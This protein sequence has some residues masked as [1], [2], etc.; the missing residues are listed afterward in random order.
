M[1]NPSA[2][3]LSIRFVRG[4]GDAPGT[5]A[6]ALALIERLR[7]T[8]IEWSY[9]TDREVIARF[10]QTAPTFV[11]AL[12]TIAPPGHAELFEGTPIIAPW[13]TRFGR[14]DA[15][16]PYICQNNPEDLRVRIAQAVALIADGTAD[17]FQF[18]DWYGNA[19]ML[20]FGQPC[21]CEHCQREFALYLGIDL[22]YRAYLR[23]RGFTHTAE[24]LEAVKA[25]AVPLWEDYRRFQ[26]Q[27]VTRF[28]RRLRGAMDQALA[29]PAELSVNGSVLHF[30]GD[31][32]AVRP[33]ISYLNGETPDFTPAGLLK[34]AEASRAQNL[35][36]V[37]SFFPDVPAA[38]Y[39]DAAFVG[40]VNQAIALC[41]CL[42]LLP[43]FP[44]DVY[45]GNEPDGALKARWYGT[46]EEYAAPY[47]TV[48]A[49]P[50]W[51]TDYAYD[52]VRIEADAV[53]VVCRH[54]E[55]AARA[56]THCLDAQGQWQT[57]AMPARDATAHID[58]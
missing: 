13:M 19:Q 1:L 8:R 56:L 32:N 16:V 29:R 52:A 27:T 17:T 30:G 37:V 10:K 31:L 58:R 14:P 9:I 55:D 6:A 44:Y 50:E 26:R 15:R 47:E 41:Y 25:E 49:H 4:A 7:P 33:F 34:L 2:I 40:R 46:Y 51:F 20:S 18:D 53:T 3:C 35:P 43:L 38:A 45:A 36:Q 23:G 12:N 5:E 57:T 22:N 28:F 21:F 42:G 39:H 24:I 48:R 54:R 11:A